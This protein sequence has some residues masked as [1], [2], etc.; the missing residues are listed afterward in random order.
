MDF[1]WLSL[2][3]PSMFIDLH[4]FPLLYRI[5]PKPPNPKPNINQ[6]NPRFQYNSMKINE[7]Q[8]NLW[9]PKT[10]NEIKWQIMWKST[11][12]TEICSK[13]IKL[14]SSSFQYSIPLMKFNENQ[15]NSMNPSSDVVSSNPERS[16]AEAA[17]HGYIL[18]LSDS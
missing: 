7:S 4:W 13:S 6:W 14:N 9:N 8:W 17:A 18:V 5:V 10:I 15:W 16:A 11:K 1:H 3:F 12:L 2:Y